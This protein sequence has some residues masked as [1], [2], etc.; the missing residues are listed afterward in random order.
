VLALLSGDGGSEEDAERGRHELEHAATLQL[1]VLGV[2]LVHAVAVGAQTLTGATGALP[3]EGVARARHVDPRGGGGV[4]E[5]GGLWRAD[6]ETIN[7]LITVDKVEEI[8]LIDT[9]NNPVKVNRIELLKKLEDT[10]LAV[11]EE[12][13]N[14][15]KVLESKR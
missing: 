1:D 15:W 10:Y 9:F 5:Q 3:G 7:F 13:Y 12:W 4:A 6:K 2:A 8:I 14:E 11:M